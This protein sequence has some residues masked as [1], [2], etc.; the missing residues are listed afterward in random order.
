M[1]AAKITESMKPIQGCALIPSRV[2]R[3]HDHY[4]SLALIATARRQTATSH[5]AS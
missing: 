1:P 4:L 3:S 5:V 2:T